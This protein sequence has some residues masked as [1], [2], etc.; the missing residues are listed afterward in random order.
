MK[1][2]R[3]WTPMISIA[4][5]SAAATPMSEQDILA[6]LH[7]ARANNSKTGL[8]GALLYFEGRFIQI[9]EGPEDEV[10]ARFAAISA[11]PRHRSI[12]LVSEDPIVQRQFPDWTMGFRPTSPELVK[13]IP[14]WDDFFDG[15]K[16]DVRIRHADNSAQQFLEW[17]TEYW[18]APTARR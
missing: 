1:V 9:L 13:E 4:Y 16:G 10:R 14:G 8:T 5:V 3:K 17:L 12:H 2:E 11:D 15:R 6:I 18:F 7:Q